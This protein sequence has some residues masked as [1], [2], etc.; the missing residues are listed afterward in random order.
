[1]TVIAYRAGVLA[2]DSRCSDEH[3]M[4][5][6]SCRKIFRLKNGALLGAAGDDDDRLVREL[7]GRATPRKLPTRQQLADTKTHFSGILVFPKGHVFVVQIGVQEYGN[8]D[9][10]YGAVSAISDEFVA[11]GSGQQYAYGAMEHG[12]SAA[13]AVRTAC[14]RD[15]MCALPLQ[16]ES[17]D[18]RSRGALPDKTAEKAGDT[19]ATRRRRPR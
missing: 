1:M 12:A 16:W 19:T 14:K 3:G 10:W 8:S 18:G 6:T 11:V 13:Q 15:L 7:L 9:E 2:S 5:L 4:H 17:I